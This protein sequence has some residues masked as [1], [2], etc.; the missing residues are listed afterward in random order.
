ELWDAAPVRVEH[1][2]YHPELLTWLRQEKARGRTLVLASAC[3]EG[4]AQAVA[5]HLGIFDLVLAS[6]ATTNLSSEAKADALVAR[7]G[8]QGFEYVGNHRHD[9]A[10]WRRA[11]VAHVVGGDRALLAKATSTTRAGHSFDRPH[12]RARAWVRAL[13]PHQWTKNSLIFV[14]LL[15]AH[16]ISELDS[17]VAA[18]LAFVSFNLAASSVYLLNDIA[19]VEND[20]DHPTKRTRP[21]AA[22]T[23]SL[24]AGWV[25]WPLLALAALGLG[26]AVS[27]LLSAVL[28]VYLVVTTAYSLA[29]KRKPLIDVLTLAVLYTIRI[30]AGAAAV[31]VT[32]ST[33]LLSFSCFFFLSLALVKRVSELYRTR[34]T[35]STAVGRGYRADD[36]EL[37][38]S[39][40]VTTSVASVLVF[41]LFISDEAT[42]KLYDTPGLLW[43]SVPL[44]LAWLMRIWLLA[45]RGEMNEDPI[46]YAIR[47]RVSICA[48]IAV[49]LIFLAA[50]TLTV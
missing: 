4:A 42:A 20:R 6:D 27:P 22:G 36:L 25:A 41:T 1:L 19:D 31:Q 26:L 15:S 10:V 14:P 46:L 50:T 33:W 8:E 45:H 17:V 7:F 49:V 47:D 9:L 35:N 3:A 30:V 37:L 24:L 34:L 39:Y 43:F 12:D 11:A 23:A 13:R 29:L 2:A 44:I 28:V 21:F 32:L 40:G 38:S 5:D 16:R 18:V 48:G